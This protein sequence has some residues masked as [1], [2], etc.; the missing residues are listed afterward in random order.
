MKSPISAI[1]ISLGNR[2]G[3]ELGALFALVGHPQ[4]P[5]HPPVLTLLV[6]PEEHQHYGC[7]P[8]RQHPQN[9][10]AANPSN[11]T[12]GA[13]GAVFPKHGQDR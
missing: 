13:G 11:E 12:P 10:S 2:V 9:V 4:S 7:E 5:G 1:A 3:L 8:A 6:P